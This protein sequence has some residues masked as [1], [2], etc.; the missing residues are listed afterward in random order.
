MDNSFRREVSLLFP[1]NPLTELPSDHPIYRSKYRLEALPKIHEH[2]GKPAQGLG[3]FFENRLLI[4]YTFSSDIGDGM[5]DL[6]VHHDGPVLHEIALKMGVNVV[7]W[8]FSP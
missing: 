4:F 2:D 1:E 5:E 7:C 3:V 8:F 6:E